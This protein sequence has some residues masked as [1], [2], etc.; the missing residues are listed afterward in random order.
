MIRC[1]WCGAQNYAID[2]WCSTCSRYL[3]WGPRAAVAAAIPPITPEAPEPPPVAAATPPSSRRRRYPGLV[4]LALFVTALG[5]AMVLALP[6]ASWFSAARMPRPSL[7]NTA[8]R[9]AAPTPAAQS[10]SAPTPSPTSEATPTPE[11]MPTPD[12]TA[13]AAPT[14]DENSTESSGPVAQP[15]LVPTVADPGA[16][17][18]HFYQAI[19]SHDFGAAAALWTTRMQARYPPVQYIDHRFAATQ[20]ISLVAERVL[21]AE[22]GVAI[23][24]VDLIERI[25]GQTRVWVGTWQLVNTTSGWLLNQP[26]LR[27]A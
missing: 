13:N 20:Q 6:V 17:V 4:L 16:A 12:A 23:V 18:A 19:S 14:P 25:D 8:M 7:P 3:E 11:A 27:A 26:N 2:N 1:P 15:A 22:D 5:V 9:S 24:Y 10:L 21:R